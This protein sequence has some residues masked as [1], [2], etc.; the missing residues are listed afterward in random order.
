MM[1][2]KGSETDKRC[3]GESL[4]VTDNLAVGD[5]SKLMSSAT[6]VK[7]ITKRELI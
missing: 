6:S 3:R 7:L 1:V 5:A 4:T 2:N